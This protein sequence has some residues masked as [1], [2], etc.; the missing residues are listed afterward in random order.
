MAD[1]AVGRA[2]LRL[3]RPY[4]TLFAATIGATLVASLLDGFTFVL[5]I[6]FLRTLFHQPAI[7][8]AGGSAVQVLLGKIAGP[9][10]AAGAPEVALRNV[11]VVLLAALI[12]KNAC[13]YISAYWSVVIQEGV[14]R[15]LRARLFAH[16]QTL[17][18]GYFQR[19]RAGQSV[20]RLVTDT[21]Q[22][23]LA[24]SAALASLLQ[25]I[26]M[27]VV[28]LTIMLG[29]SPRLTLIALLFA[30]VLLFVIR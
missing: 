10:L 23:K 19:T 18:L 5:L 21:D 7:A 6:P 29:L 4:T 14:V 24:V 25:N 16:L 12:L 11:V 9:F 2:L 15:D 27:I 28:Y 1:R 17:P 3:L 26:L 22:V 8:S 30:P 20:A 13:E